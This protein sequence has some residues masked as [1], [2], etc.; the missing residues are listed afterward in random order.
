M[1]DEEEGTRLDIQHRGWK[2]VNGGRNY[3]APIDKVLGDE[4]AGKKVIDIGTGELNGVYPPNC[5]ELTW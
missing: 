1:S 2:A 3:I 4:G 5:V